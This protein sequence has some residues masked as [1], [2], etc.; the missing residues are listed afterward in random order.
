MLVPGN[1]AQNLIQPQAHGGVVA[2]QGRS[3]RDQVDL[4]AYI[5]SRYAKRIQ[6]LD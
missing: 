4:L 1:G 6:T 2:H 3:H 5:P